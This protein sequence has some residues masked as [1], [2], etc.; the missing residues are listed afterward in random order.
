MATL[1]I[2]LASLAPAPT[3]GVA[4]RSIRSVLIGGY[5]AFG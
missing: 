2:S 4:D 5:V 1:R 3:R